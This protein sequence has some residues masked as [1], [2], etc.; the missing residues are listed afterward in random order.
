M[1][2]KLKL[3]FLGLMRKDLKSVLSVCPCTV[4]IKPKSEIVNFS[5]HI[6]SRTYSAFYH[7]KNI[8]KVTGD[9]MSEKCVCAFISSRLDYCNRLFTGVSKSADRQTSADP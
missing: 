4:K 2:I 6:K 1:R 8:V 3:L 7:L 5:S 9:W